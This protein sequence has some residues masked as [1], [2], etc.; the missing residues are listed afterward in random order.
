MLFD[1]IMFLK[2]EIDSKIKIISTTSKTSKPIH[3]E[4]KDS[5]DTKKCI[6]NNRT[7]E[8]NKNQEVSSSQSVLKQLNSIQIKNHAKYLKY[9]TTKKMPRIDE[10]YSRNRSVTLNRYWCYIKEIL[11]TSYYILVQMTPEMNTPNL[12]YHELQQ[13]LCTTIVESLMNTEQ[14]SQNIFT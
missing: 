8:V 13:K 6:S 7:I 1:R 9:R 4:H 12:H 3:S 2:Q 10:I 11:S 5:S 14:T